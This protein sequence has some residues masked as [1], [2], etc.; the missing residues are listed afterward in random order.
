MSGL[1]TRG[2]ICAR[3]DFDKIIAF[4]MRTKL[5]GL[6]GETDYLDSSY[7]LESYTRSLERSICYFLD[8]INH[9]ASAN[10]N[11]TN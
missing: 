5:Q 8:L 1:Y 9:T 11:A 3:Q 2:R 10:G 7:I 6:N 4:A